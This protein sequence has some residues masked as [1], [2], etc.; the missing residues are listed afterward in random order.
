MRN[1]V[2]TARAAGT[3]AATAAAVALALSGCGGSPS[4]DATTASAGGSASASASASASPSEATLP[5]GS[6]W[7]DAPKSGIRF[8][9]PEDWKSMSFREVIDSGDKEAIDEAAKSMGVTPEQLDTIADQ[10]E[11]I[12]FGP[13]VK[14]FAVNINAV[15]QPNTAM[16]SAAEATSQLQ[17]IGGKVGKAVEGTTSMGKSLVVPYTLKVQDRTVQGRTLLIETDDGVATLTVSHVSGDQADKLT[18]A[19]LDNVDAL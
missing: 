13:T 19:I 18:K 10:I 1:F 12:V 16:P 2:V 5:E 14:G 3:A 4:T 8:P 17:Q 9:V 7:V 6:Q 15:P 11:V